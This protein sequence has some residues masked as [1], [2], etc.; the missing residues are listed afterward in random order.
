LFGRH[1]TGNTDE[2]EVKE[3]S[4]ELSSL[5]TWACASPSKI[6]MAEDNGKF[7]GYDESWR[8]PPDIT[9]QLSGKQFDLAIRHR[10]NIS[11]AACSNTTTWGASV[12]ILAHDTLK[13]S[14]AS[15]LAWQARN[16]L[17]LLVGDRVSIRSVS[18]EIA[19]AAGSSPGAAPSKRLYRQTGKHDSPDHCCPK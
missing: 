7:S 8:L 14:T 13:L 18:I 1:F 2:L 10:M 9:V 3:Y 12:S 11:H 6:T 4:V 17:S 19:D 16:L 15:E 5:S